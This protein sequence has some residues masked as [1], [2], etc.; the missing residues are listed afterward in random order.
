MTT[1]SVPGNMS[2]FINNFKP[3]ESITQRG[4]NKNITALFLAWLLL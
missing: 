2:M 1:M 3:G 4:Q